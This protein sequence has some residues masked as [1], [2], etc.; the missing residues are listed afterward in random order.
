MAETTFACDPCR[1]R[2]RKVSTPI[3]FASV[4][5]N[6]CFPVRQK[7]PCVFTVC[8]EERCVR[9]RS[10]ARPTQVRKRVFARIPALITL[11]PAQR[12]YVAS[13]EARVALLESILGDA[14]ARDTA[15][16]S[17][18][19]SVYEGHPTPTTHAATSPPPIASPQQPRLGLGLAPESEPEF[20]PSD[21][22]AEALVPI[23]HP[24]P[25][26]IAMT[27]SNE[28]DLGMDG[29]LPIVSLDMEHKLLAQF[30]DWQRMHMPFV[31]P[32]PFLAAYALHAQTAHPDEPI[33]PPPPPPPLDVYSGRAI[34]VPSAESV[35]P[36]PELAQFISPLL[37]D[38]VFAVAALFHGNLD[39]SSKFYKRAEARIMR[40]AAN[41][42]LATIQGV[43]LMAM[44]ELGH[45][46]APASWTLNGV[47][48]NLS[49]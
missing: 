37:L 10:H 34:S 8:K 29:Y 15:S 47:F 14:G 41:P 44:A 4:L 45:A 1:R 38:A 21:E 30:W 20:V 40:E 5:A 42:R 22:A 23:A 7:N 35:H 26:E 46:R 12:D 36:D 19:A 33:P 2:K 39:L 43:Q 25:G 16:P 3:C 9:L 11:R 32:V 48:Y 13:L 31:A 49:C 27:I 28:L 24:S 17:E 6:Y 18:L